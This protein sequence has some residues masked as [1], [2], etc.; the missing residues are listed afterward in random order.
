MWKYLFISVVFLLLTGTCYAQWTAVDSLRLKNLLKN[1]E[2]IKLNREA[3]K[4]IKFSEDAETPRMS[5]EKRW[6]RFDESLPRVISPLSV[7]ESDSLYNRRRITDEKLPL[8]MLE[9]YKP[10]YVPLP[11]DTLS[12]TMGMKLP[13]PEG[14]S[15]GNGV[16]VNGGLF[17]GLDLLQIFTKEFWQFKKKRMRAD[18]HEALK[19]Y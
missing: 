18:T 8:L 6:M 12:I 13:P 19:K 2:E 16:R 15:L 3:V 5:K 14:I 17:S 4:H 11:L 9:T 7:I 1:G 10:A